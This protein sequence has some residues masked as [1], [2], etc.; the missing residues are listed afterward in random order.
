M[1]CFRC[2]TDVADGTP[3]CPNC[4]QRFMGGRKTFTATTTSF[5]ALEKR[6]LR[7]RQ[8]AESLQFPIGE[9]INAR[10]EIK[11]LVGTGPLGV[12]YRVHDQEIEEDVALKVIHRSLV[13]DLEAAEVEELCRAVRKARKL[14]QQNIVRLYDELI[15]DGQHMF[16]MQLLEGLT[17]R[18]V[19]GLRREKGQRFRL[20]EAEPILGQICLALGHAH[21]HTAHG[22]LK[23]EN[24]LILPDVLKLTDF[25]MYEALPRAV[26]AQAQRE[27][28]VDAYLAP[29]ILEGRSVDTRADIF[30]LG[31]LLYEL[32]TGQVYAPDAPPMT[33]FA[34]EIEG[35]VD[36]LEALIKQACDPDPTKRFGD[37][38]AFAESLGTLVDA[39]ELSS[40][41]IEAVEELLP[42]E[43]T[44]KVRMRHDV[45]DEP[46][47]I[48]ST[49]LGMAQAAGLVAA[50]AARAGSPAPMAEA[51]ESFIEELGGEE[52]DALIESSDAS[53]GT[54]MV[55]A[56][57]AGPMMANV[58]LAPP[59]ELDLEP[60][61]V[62]PA[63][64]AATGRSASTEVT[65]ARG[66]ERPLPWLLE[67]TVGFSLI[68][69]MVVGVVGGGAWWLIRS[70][71]STDAPA[72]QVVTIGDDPDTVVRKTL[73]DPPSKATPEAPTVVPQPA[74]VA[75][76]GTVAVAT[77]DAATV[78]ENTPDAAPT[79]VAVEPPQPE[80]VKPEP[81]APE[82]VAVPEPAKP[83]PIAAAPQVAPSKEAPDAVAAT[84]RPA[85]PTRRAPKPSTVKEE[86]PK[87]DPVETP[88]PAPKEE[89]VA[90]APVAKA[91]VVEKPAPKEEPAPARRAVAEEKPSPAEED[92]PAPANT[93]DTLQCPSEMK[94]V[95]LGGFPK[96]ALKRGVIKGTEAVSAAKSGKAFCVDTYEYPGSGRPKTRVTFAAAKGMCASKGKRLCSGSEWKRACGAG[97]AYP[98]GGSF[99]PNRCNTED[100]DE[101]ERSVTSSGRFKKCR[102][103]FGV[104][105][106]SGN[107][108]EWTSD[109][110]VRGGTSADADEDV[111]CNGSE[112][113]GGGSSSSTVGFRCCKSFE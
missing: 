9:V 13:E 99:N 29:E 93:D 38:E 110:R 35:D 62:V 81:V 106:M 64:G 112:R 54:P 68:V 101:E 86:P 82:P 97:R 49:H 26:F 30:S 34:D 22:D 100:D 102:S 95:T 65:P 66:V 74:V 108:A 98:Y 57:A 61:A 77:P 12:V 10:Y 41:D 40:V 70:L 47:D 51:E 83:E 59:P 3:E 84:V 48:K 24:V 14:S 89:P 53:M 4:G 71:T 11:D 17:L 19:M 36:A 23:P 31:A 18:K 90:K 104:Y 63:E 60:A 87:Q 45:V 105:D 55:D 103:G 20:F 91:P 52:L 56:P 1:I 15:V 7:A 39:V 44:R 2:G 28:K 25:A 69:L 27:A 16:T 92:K 94:V 80:P 37:V 46:A 58:D 42:E 85:S 96:K 21:R 78:A 107:V 33:D 50:S 76:A 113:R 72:A 79:V 109:Q 5:K 8:A 32:L 43:V 88:K 111:S 67:S 6:K 75:D 73:T